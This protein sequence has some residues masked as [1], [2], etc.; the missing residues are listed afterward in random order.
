MAT[1][2]TTY[3]TDS[4]GETS[5]RI[6]RLNPIIFF[7]KAT[8]EI[9]NR[10]LRFF[11]AAIAG[12]A[13]N[14][15]GSVEKAHRRIQ[16]GHVLPL[17]F[18]NPQ[19]ELF[20]NIINWLKKKGF[21][22]ISSREL[23]H[24][25]RRKEAPHQKSAWISF[26][27]GWR[28]NVDNVIPT[29]VEYDVPATFFISTYPVETSGYFWWSVVRKYNSKVSSKYKKNLTDL[30][31]LP[32]IEIETIVN[33]LL[34][35]EKQI[36]REAM[37]FEEV[38]EISILPQVTIGCHGVH[39]LLMTRCSEDELAAEILDSKSTLERWIDKPVK[40]FAYPK[41]VFGQREKSILKKY[42]YELAAG[43]NNFLITKDTDLYVV[44]RFGVLN[45]A[46]FYEA[47][48]H[49]LGIWQPFKNKF[50]LSLKIAD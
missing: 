46:Y 50:K 9:M 39:H 6:E 49:V 3:S 8:D 14:F 13:L 4:L 10:H 2:I 20:K 15:S 45:E 47:I 38:I 37:T 22:F 5:Q 44:P 36:Q 21:A 29:L 26:D 31:Q 40:Y 11:F 24:I 25:L 7:L 1:A 42:G 32:W 23:I 16:D 18:H 19:K 28:E 34:A 33:E 12:L 48:C 30:W 43:T 27:D 41:G 35:K 17:Y